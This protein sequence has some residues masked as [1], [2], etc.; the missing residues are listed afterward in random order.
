MSDNRY[1]HFSSN[2]LIRH[3]CALV[4][5][6]GRGTRLKGLTAKVAKPAVAF[7]GKYRIIDFTLSNCYNSGIKSVGVL[8]QYMAHELIQH[9]QGTWPMLSPVR[10]EGVAILPAQQR[11]GD[12]W[13]RGTADAVY[14]NMDL[15]DKSFERVLILGGD[16]VYKMDYSRMVNFHVENGADVTVACIRKPLSQASSFGV[17]GLDEHGTIVDFEE[18]PA[19]P[20]PDQNDP[21]QALVSMG[22]YIFNTA[23]L[24]KELKDGLMKP[25]YAHD[26]GHNVIPEMLRTHKVCG[27]VFTESGHPGGNAYWRDVGDI[28]EYFAASMDLVSPDPLLDLYDK[29]W[30][31]VTQQK[32]RPGAKFVFNDDDRKGF[33]IDSVISAGSIVSGAQIQ[34]SLL[35]TDVRVE[36]KSVLDQV[37]VLDGACIGK[38]CK[39]RKVIIAEGTQI[40]DGTVIGYD[41]SAD[42]DR[43]TVS[44]QGVALVTGDHFAK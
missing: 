14:Q 18:K 5:A 23:V 26:F 24:D 35:S 38:D 28:D 36:E 29:D 20:K 21:E 31:I 33:A 4:L 32:Q 2:S 30:P 43:Y 22:I 10:S 12:D 17:L 3:T 13:Y 15:I 42:K 37:V 27:Y 9:V 19:N 8:T 1:S 25:G 44:E 39:L 40:P 6:G 34:R 16:H 7:G 11:T 41:P